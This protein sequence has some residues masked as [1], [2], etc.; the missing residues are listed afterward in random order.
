MAPLFYLRSLLVFALTIFDASAAPQA[1]EKRSFIIERQQTGNV[2]ARNGVAEVARAYRKHGWAVPESMHAA[3]INA[4]NRATSNQAG[5]T[6][7]TPQEGDSEFLSPVKVG[8]QTLMMDFDTGSA[9]FWVFNTQL[10]AAQTKGHSVYDP[11]K[12]STF[13]PMPFSTF[14]IQYGD[15]SGASGNVGKDTVSVG[16]ATVPQQ[17]I[18]LAN[19]VTQSFVQD[20]DSDGLMGLGFM[21][22]NTI[23]PAKQDTFFG[24][25][26][27]TLKD[28]LFTANLRHKTVGSYQFGAVDTSQFVG[29]MKMTRVDP[30]Q[31]Y[32]QFPSKS[33]AVG[34]DAPVTNPKANPAIADTG[35]SLLLVDD[36]L[37]KAY[38]S[39]VPGAKQN[40]AGYV[41]PCSSSLPDLKME[42]GSEGYMA[43]IPGELL[44]YQGLGGGVCY[45]GLQS[46]QGQPIQILG[47]I[48]FK[49]QFVVFDA[50]G[51]SIG[52]APHA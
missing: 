40:D 20:T 14:K 29:K 32:W 31:G 52:F 11:T 28:P 16:S 35:T 22:G 25:I 12:S 7:A 51:P 2:R 1:I 46:S 45:G 15:K 13:R 6:E 38:Y 41:F 10:S 18:E 24:N 36:V 39:K 9:D 49:S 27:P 42:L 48:L 5:S 50:R 34:T 44:N 21:K 8:G 4:T 37:L 19:Q 26:A 43:T 3:V 23:S 33:F 30:S 17:A 47:D